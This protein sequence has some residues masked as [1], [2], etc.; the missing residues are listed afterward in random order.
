MVAKFASKLDSETTQLNF[1]MDDDIDNDITTE[2]S[3]T[4]AENTMILVD[5]DRKVL[6]SDSEIVQVEAGNVNGPLAL[7]KVMY[8]DED[9]SDDLN[10]V[11]NQDPLEEEQFD[12]TVASAIVSGDPV[13]QST[14]SASTTV[15]NG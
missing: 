1:I 6:Q 14:Q 11:D 8:V 5:N 13:E 2:F 10:T 7:D 15:I 3:T 9:E 4:V 12:N